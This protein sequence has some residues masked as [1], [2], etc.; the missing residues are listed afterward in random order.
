MKKILVI[1]A[2][3]GLAAAF[4][5]DEGTG[6]SI[7]DLSISGTFAYESEY[8]FRG[9]QF[10]DESFQPS[11]EIGYPVADGNIYAGIW[12][13]DPISAGNGNA[14][15]GTQEIDFYGGFAYPI[16]V[17]TLDVG[18]TYYWFPQNETSGGD[19]FKVDDFKDFVAGD[20]DEFAAANIDQTQEVFIGASAE[21]PDF[22]VS[23][24]LYFYYDF[25]LEAVTVEASVGYSYDL[26][27]AVGVDG[28]AIDTSAY[29]GVVDANDANGNLDSG[30]GFVNADGEIE[31][32]ED[33]PENG[34]TYAGLSADLV[35]S[36]NEFVSA[37][38]GIRWA[39]N[40]D[41]ADTDGDT[42]G[43]REDVDSNQ[44]WYGAS[45][46]FSY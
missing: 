15:G 20:Q 43:K 44:F 6:S 2:L 35:Y 13:N 18:F 7:S 14:Q 9:L 22:P 17:V 30:F 26:G 19:T 45:I 34:Y 24:A 40:N 31:R 33:S 5:Q 32:L 4:A 46:G 41:E 10:A 23:P 11:V 8:V 3:S 21:I 38:F 28:I 1:A 12:V 42:G 16:D 37:S 29:V 36:F 39:V 27:E 25:A